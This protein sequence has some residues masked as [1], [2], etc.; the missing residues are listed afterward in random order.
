[1]STLYEIAGDALALDALLDEHLSANDGEITPE[2][3]ATAN[4]W[5]LENEAEFVAKAEGY[6]AVMR[7]NESQASLLE[8]RAKAFKAMA[9]DED[10]LAKSRASKVDALKGRL[11][12][13]FKLRG[14]E[15]L[16]AGPYKLK[17]QGN[18]GVQPL[19]IDPNIVPE[20][21]PFEFL[22]YTVNSAAVRAHL[23]AGGELNWARLGERGQS[24]RIK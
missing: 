8:A 15:E 3:E 5:I 16:K 17:L 21:L 18:G 9:A 23:E 4:A 1:M 22:T 14:I 12:W 20:L 6:L 10:K 19:E 7:E 13:Y 24:I 2:F 11:K